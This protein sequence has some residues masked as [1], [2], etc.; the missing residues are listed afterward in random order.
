MNTSNESRATRSNLRLG[1][2]GL[3]RGIGIYTLVIV[4]TLVL[5]YLIASH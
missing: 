4:L 3:I 1:P 5:S 2:T